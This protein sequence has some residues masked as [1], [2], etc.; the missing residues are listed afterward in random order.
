MLRSSPIMKAVD[1]VLAAEARRGKPA[2]TDAI[3]QWSDGRPG[4]TGEAVAEG[5]EFGYMKRETGSPASPC[6]TFPAEHGSW[7]HD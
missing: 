7:N 3:D 1:A 5:W 6:V 2:R 4:T